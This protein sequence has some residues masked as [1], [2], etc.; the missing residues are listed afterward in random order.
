[1]IVKHASTAAMLLIAATVPAIAKPKAPV[2]PHNVLIFVAD[3]LRADSVNAKDAPT[4]WKLASAGVRFTN[5][6]SLYPTIT[7]VNASAIATGHYIGDTGN[8]GNQLY[9]GFSVP[10]AGG[11]MTPFLENDAI[12]G[13]MNDHFGGNYLNEESLLAAARKAGFQT[14]AL[15]KVGA[16]PIQDVTARDGSGTIVIDDTVGSD[17]GIPVAPDIAAAMKAAG[18]PGTAPKTS[19]PNDAQER[20]LLDIATKVVL[21]KF[22]IMKKPFAILFWSRDPDSTQHVQKDSLGKLMPGINGATS[23]AGI[24][25]ADATL[26]GLLATLKSLGL[27]KTTDVFVTADHGFSTIDKHSQTSAAAGYEAAGGPENAIDTQ[28]AP[29]PVGERDLP[30]GFLAIDLADA[31]K[32][33]LYDPNTQLPVNFAAG[34]HPSYGNGYIG[35]DLSNPDVIV[36]SNGGSDEIWLPGVN[37]AVLA[38]RIVDILAGEDYV[39]GMFVNDALGSIPGALPFSSISL[40]GSAKTP[41]PAIIVNFRSFSV[42]GCKPEPLCA[43]EVADTSLAT[44]QGMHGSFSRADTMNFMAVAGPDFKARFADPVPSSN[45]DIA[46]TVAHVLGL[47]IASKGRLTGRAL[48]EALPKGKKVVITRGWAVS[49]PAANGEKTV[50]EYQQVGGARYFDAAGFPGRTVGLTAH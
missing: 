7:T 27:D 11:A 16:T 1:M 8:F 40:I 38:G 26:A 5:P 48:T 20:Y 2:Q 25:N 32:L 21:P 4:M 39:S 19:V 42:L 35:N 50:L 6:H 24:K 33:P 37:A 49:R 13:E 41:K 22:K 43:A 12:L 14:A 15:G 46:P 23:K 30:P 36:A 17:T 9:V 45:A 28:N 10:E 34:E 44:G 3:G 18:I 29:P 31:L 47:T